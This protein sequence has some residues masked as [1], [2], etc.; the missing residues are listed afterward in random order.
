MSKIQKYIDVFKNHKITRDIL[1]SFYD[2]KGYFNKIGLFSSILRSL[3]LD[4]NSKPIP[5]AT[6]PYLDFIIEHLNQDMT[7]FEYGAGN[8]TLFL[9]TKVKEVHS[10]EH[11]L[12]WY[13]HL[14]PQLPQN[15]FLYYIELKYDGDYARF[16]QS[17][18]KKFDLVI[19]DGRDRVN[20]MKQAINA[21]NDSG[22]IVLDDSERERYNEGV[23]YLQTQGFRKIDFHGLKPTSLEQG[24]TT[25]FYRDNNILNI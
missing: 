1:Y 2:N 7:I 9:N 15:S 8:S 22:V 21:I 3:P 10:I 18:N 14:K 12:K 16:P 19:V 20:C 23:N 4:Q 25:I 11:D 6:Y 5:L 13:N 17:I 24:C